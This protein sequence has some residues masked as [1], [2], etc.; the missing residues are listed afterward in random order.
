M[1]IKNCAL[2]IASAAIMT[3]ISIPSMA[4]SDDHV[5]KIAADAGVSKKVAQKMLESL[6][7]SIT[8][9][10]ANDEKVVILEL[11]TFNIA[12]RPA[13]QG[14]DPQTGKDFTIPG[15]KVIKFVPAKQ[16]TNAI[17]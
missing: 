17:Q 3:V 14:R 10:L 12:N 15:K 2:S 6:V 13:R 1:K 5:A 11:G 9:D 16:L 7:S 8:K 4:I